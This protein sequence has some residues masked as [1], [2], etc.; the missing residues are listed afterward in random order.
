MHAGKNASP[1]ARRRRERRR[2]E[3]HRR[4][5]RRA[6]ARGLMFLGRH[7]KTASVNSRFG[8]AECRDAS[9][10]LPGEAYDCDPYTRDCRTQVAFIRASAGVSNL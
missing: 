6:V 9:R 2:R 8:T 7:P 4:N 5:R 10:R 1:P 3:H